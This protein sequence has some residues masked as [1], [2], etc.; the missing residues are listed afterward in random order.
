MSS[1]L[2]GPH[3]N[4][5]GHLAHSENC[6]MDCLWDRKKLQDVRNV[7]ARF[8]YADD[9]GGGV[10]TDDEPHLFLRL[11]EEDY[12]LLTKAMDTSE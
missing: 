5:V 1:T 9:M 2:R 7:V 12:S 6:C 3:N 4:P 11:S 10:P 8:F